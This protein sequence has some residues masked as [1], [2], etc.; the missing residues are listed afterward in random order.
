MDKA[1]LLQASL[2]LAAVCTS[3]AEHLGDFNGDG[4]SDVLLRHDEGRWRVHLMDRASA[5]PGLPVRMTSKL[6]WYWMGTGDFN[7]DGSDDVMLRRDDGVWVYYPLNGPQVIATERGWANLTRNLDWRIVG[8]AD[9]NDDGR[10]DILMRRNDGAWIYYPMNGKRVIADER[11]W[12]N[13]PRDPDWRMAGV[14]DFDGDGRDDVLLRHVA[15]GTWRY[16]AMNGR[17]VVVEQPP[18]ALV[19]QDQNWRFAGIGDFDGDARDDVLLRHT[20][21]RWRHHDIAGATPTNVDLDPDRRRRRRWQ[22]RH[23][24]PARQRR[25]ALAPS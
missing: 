5:G 10:D 20:S 1:H 15:V 8:V 13:L 23:P 7:G 14:G 22:G 9:F 3:G 11:G 16:Y 19:P 18:T 25:M 2:I 21:G 24:P 4:K 12:V 6:E 17:R